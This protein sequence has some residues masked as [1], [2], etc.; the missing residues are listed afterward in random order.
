MFKLNP[1]VLEQGRRAWPK[2][3]ARRFGQS[4]T[5]R[6]HVNGM[7]HASCRVGRA[8]D[9]RAGAFFKRLAICRCPDGEIAK[10]IARADPDGIVRLSARPPGASPP[11]ILTPGAEVVIA[12]GPFRGFSGIRQGMSAHDRELVLINIL[13]ASRPVEIAAGLIVPQ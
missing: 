4:I 6:R 8:I 1:I 12:D 13:G 10:L 11:R 5:F 2:R 3:L 9:A 7:A